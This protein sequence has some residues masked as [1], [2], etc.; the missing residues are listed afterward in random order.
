MSFECFYS[1]IKA[2]VRGQKNAGLGQETEN[3][4]SCSDSVQTQSSEWIESE[5]KTTGVVQ[6]VL[7]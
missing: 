3:P 2:A 4:E 1:L 6:S 7:Q 5:K